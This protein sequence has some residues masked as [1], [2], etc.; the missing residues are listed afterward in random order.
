MKSKQTFVDYIMGITRVDNAANPDSA[1]SKTKQP[2]RKPIITKQQDEM[3][4]HL[5]RV[6][7]V[8]KQFGKGW[9]P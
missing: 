7:S 3:R 5:E 4:Q 6:H 2:K 1:Y 9:G 8:N